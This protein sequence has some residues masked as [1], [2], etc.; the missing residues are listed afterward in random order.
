MPSLQVFDRINHLDTDSRYKLRSLPFTDYF[1]EMDLTKEQKEERIALAKNLEDVMTFFFYLVLIQSEFAY[2]G[3][4]SAL[5]AKDTFRERML[6]TVAQ[7]ME[8]N[9]E[10]RRQI[11]N[12]VEETTRVTIE[13]LVILQA[14][15]GRGETNEAEE[16]YLS[17]DR[18]RFIAEE[19]SNTLFNITDYYKAIELGYSTKTWVTMM[20]SRVRKDHQK[21]EGETIPIN[22]LFLVGGNSYMRFPRDEEYGA[23]PKQIISCRCSITY[24]P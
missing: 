23:S 17:D 3:A 6:N 4:I 14:I 18:A 21:M 11:E 12:M 2:M 9:D 22:D 19:E 1:G 7:H 20:D 15:I 16:Y 8:L 24:N 5:E 10:I 13:H